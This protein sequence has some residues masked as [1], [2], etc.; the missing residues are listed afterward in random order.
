M[1]AMTGTGA[2]AQPTR[3]PKR[4]P[5]QGPQVEVLDEV[6]VSLHDHA[7]EAWPVIQKLPDGTLVCSFTQ[8][9]QLSYKAHA[10]PY[11]LPMITRSTDGGRSWVRHPVC[12]SNYRRFGNEAFGL[13]ALE[14]GT[15]LA[16]V[17]QLY[18]E[19]TGW[20]TDGYPWRRVGGYDLLQYRSTDG[21]ATWEEPR[22]VDVG[23]RSMPFVMRPLVKVGDELLM[24]LADEDVKSCYVLRSADGGET[25]GDESLICGQEGW[26]Y[27]EPAI[28]LLPSGRILCVLRTWQ[29]DFP[30]SGGY[31][32]LHMCYSDDAG[33]TW[34]KPED[35]GH[36]GYPS[37]LMSLQDG[38][39]LCI[40]GHRIEPVSVRVLLSEDE[41]RTWEGPLTV[42][43]LGHEDMGYP[44]AVQ[45]N[46]GSIFGV[47]YGYDGRP[48]WTPREGVCGIWGVRF[49]A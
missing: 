5:V 22:K 34:S 48:N 45:L 42:A 11:N 43:T 40:Y 19:S 13:T 16:H 25:W 24:P 32:N 36:Y 14:D 28:L 37:Y 47:Y 46:D 17:L 8:H 21:G 44:T 12:I 9:M 27:T 23:E 33:R 41:G 15:L 20:A 1:T 39:V 4:P 31:V 49:R 30:H 29:G 10:C 26:F 3:H 35:M 6:M 38:R 7:F 2:E 18:W